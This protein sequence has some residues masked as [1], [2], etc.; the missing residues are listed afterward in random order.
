MAGAVIAHV[1]HVGGT[2]GE[3]HGLA[4]PSHPMEQFLHRILQHGDADHVG[5]IVEG[6]GE[7]HGAVHGGGCTMGALF[8]DI[9]HPLQLGE[10]IGTELDAELRTI[11][12]DGSGGTF[13]IFQ[14]PPE[15]G[16][17]AHVGVFHLVT[18][19]A[20][21]FHDFLA[22]AELLMGDLGVGIEV[23]AECNSGMPVPLDGPG[24]V[25]RDHGI[26]S[27]SSV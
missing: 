16:G 8:D 26:S 24:E 18:G 2:V 17:V 12:Q 5:K 27:L 1:A 9:V 22:G 3:P 14:Y 21:Q 23:I 10:R 25:V 6:L 4:G 7:V 20:E 13:P 15:C 11:R 19:L